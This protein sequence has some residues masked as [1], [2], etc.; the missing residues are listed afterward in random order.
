MSVLKSKI[1]VQTAGNASRSCQLFQIFAGPDESCKWP[2]YSLRVRSF[3]LRSCISN[4]TP[5]SGTHLSDLTFM[6]EGNPDFINMDN[7]KLINFPKHYLIIRTIKYLQQYQSCHYELTAK[8][9]LYSLLYAVPSLQEKELYELSL[10]RE[11][12][13]SLLKD[14]LWVLRVVQG[15]YY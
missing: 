12:R 9:P 8:E 7:N 5:Y 6:D 4:E 1:D 2:F 14:M 11:P 10:E 15:Y 3:I 13:D